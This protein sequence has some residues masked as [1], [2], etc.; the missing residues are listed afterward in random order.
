MAFAIRVSTSYKEVFSP[1][2]ATESRCLGSRCLPQW[3]E[4]GTVLHQATCINA[5]HYDPR[6]VA[7]G[8]VGGCR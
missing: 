7:S 1:E 2:V 6:G 3:Q 8:R 4:V 5:D